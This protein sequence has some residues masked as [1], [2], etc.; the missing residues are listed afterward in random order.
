[1]NSTY[2]IIAT[3]AARVPEQV[4]VRFLPKAHPR[5]VPATYRCRQLHQQLTGL[6]LEFEGEAFQLQQ[7]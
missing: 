3:T 7:G 5:A 1:M 2:E 6:E 4:A